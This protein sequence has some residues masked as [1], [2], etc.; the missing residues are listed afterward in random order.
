MIDGH[1]HLDK[2][3]LTKDYV[4]RFIHQAIKMGIDDLQIV[5]HTHRFQEFKPMYEKYKIVPEQKAW[6]DKDLEY[7][8][9]DYIALIEEMKKEEL[10][11]K[12]SFGLEVCYAHED[13]ELIRKLLSIYKWDFLIGSLHGINFYMY[14]CNWSLKRFWDVFDT[15]DL[16]HEY[17]E[18]TYRLIQS[19]IFTQLGHADTF[20]MFNYYPSFDLKPYYEKL[21]KLLNEHHMKVEN[22][23]GCYYRYNHKDMGLNDELL[24]ILKENHCMLLTSTDAH[25][26]EHVGIHIKDVWD[27]TMN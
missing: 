10:P 22:N 11:I 26:P 14:D 3:P 13:E 8:I 23:V 7:S 2:G 20:K 17:Y 9:Y 18:E 19:D 1:T 27:K 16:Y 5:N 4:Y 25:V 6:L 24:K 21:A 12:V 15:N